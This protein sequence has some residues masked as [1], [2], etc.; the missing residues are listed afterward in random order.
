MLALPDK[1]AV[2]VLRRIGL[3]EDD[4]SPDGLAKKKLVHLPGNLYRLKVKA[5]RVFYTFDDRYVSLLDIRKRDDDTYDHDAAPATVHLGGLDA[6]LPKKEEPTVP[7]WDRPEKGSGPKT[8]PLPEP[9]TQELLARLRVPANHYKRL[10]AAKSEE[11]LLGCPGVPDDI[12]LTVF[13]ALVEPR[14]EQLLSQPDLILPNV[15]DLL[16]YRDGSLIDFLLKLDPEQEVIVRKNIAGAGPTLVKG[17]PGTGKSTVAIY[18]T[19]EILNFLPKS[20]RPRVL[21]TTYTNALIAFTE[22]LLEQLL[23]PDRALVDVRTADS[24]VRAIVGSDCG[25]AGILGGNDVR[26]FLE[27]AVGS[28]IFDGNALVQKTQRESLGRLSTDYLQEEIG[29]VIEGRGLKSIDEYLQAQRAGRLV[30]LNATQRRAVW[31]ARERLNVLLHEK[32]KWTWERMRRRALEKVEAGVWKNPYDAVFV[33][34]AQDLSPVALRLLTSVCSSP[35]RLFLTADANQCIYGSTFSWTSVHESLRFQGGR[36][37]VIRTN[38]RST[39]EV[40]EAARSYL[41]AGI[42]EESAEETKYEHSGAL[43]AVRSVATVKE[44]TDLLARY[45]KEAAREARLGTSSGAVLVPSERT[46]KPLAEALTDAGVPAEFMPGKSLDLKKPVVK[47]I[48][49]KSAKGLEFP[50]VAVAGFIGLSSDAKGGG[51]TEAVEETLR[52]DR[53]SYFVAMTRAM[54][55]LLVVVPKGTQSP[56]LKGFA[57]ELWNVK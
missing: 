24:L 41:A 12:K 46:G 6:E 47:I 38:H 51:S 32:K 57:P 45:L 17:G 49:L 20:P 44:E 14:V 8:T 33:D 1:D 19:R 39:R 37:G 54:R 23:G 29:A 16:K 28:A 31:A 52:R 11:D 36:T 25:D 2:L 18:R 3:L 42:L 26:P 40:G 43:P 35:S 22:Q 4:P 53:R 50:I 10:I 48:T 13:N 15:S 21:F 34:E 7:S 5:F 27:A 30:P 56:L 9:V 55:T